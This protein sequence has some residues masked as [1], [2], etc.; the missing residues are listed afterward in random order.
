MATNPTS[1]IYHLLREEEPSKPEKKTQAKKTAPVVTGGAKVEKKP[2]QST[3]TPHNTGTLP[4]RKNQRS[5]GRGGDHGSRIHKLEKHEKQ[6]DAPRGKRIFDKRSGTG[7]ARNDTKKGG[8]GKGSWG[9]PKNNAEVEAEANPEQEKVEKTVEETAVQTPAEPEEKIRSL[10]EFMASQ[11]QGKKEIQSLLG[12]QE[13]A[14]RSLDGFSDN[15]KAKL[16][17]VP[18]KSAQAQLPTGKASISSGLASDTMLPSVPGFQ[19]VPQPIGGSGSGGRGGRG[20]SRGGRGGSR[21]GRGGSRG[22]RGGS[23]GGNNSGSRGDSEK[24]TSGGKGKGK[25]S[26]NA[27]LKVDFPPL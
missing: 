12:N 1:N 10:D 16:Q 17:S 26:F 24:K 27:D 18:L 11:K 2:T 7:R 5:G 21:G 6:G 25:S 14:V 20:G 3:G 13:K 9:N 23:R 22:G 8:S 4:D 15:E 19:F